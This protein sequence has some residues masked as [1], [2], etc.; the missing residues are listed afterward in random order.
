MKPVRYIVLLFCLAF[1]FCVFAQN[2]SKADFYQDGQ[3]VIITYS[4]D[5]A[6]DV[7]VQVSTDG[8][9]T[10]SAPLKHVSGHVGNNV[11]A[12]NNRIVWDV[13]SEYEKLVGNRFQFLVTA[14]GNAVNENSGNVVK[15]DNAN[16]IHNGHEYV[17]LGLPSGTL[18]ATCNVGANAPEEYGDYF[19]WGE[20]T[21]KSTYNWSTYKYCNGSYDT[22]TKYC[23]SSSYGTV[24]NKTTLEAADD[25]AR[26]NWGGAWRMPT[27]AEQEELLNECTW[28]WT[29]LNGLSGY[30]VTG[31]N[32]NS[33]FLPAAGHRRDSILGS[34]GSDG[35]YW[36][37]S[38]D[39]G[40]SVSVYVLRIYSSNFD[41]VYDYRY[42]GLSVRPV[43]SSQ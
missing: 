22:Q 4:L 40:S 37:S 38:L 19:A 11:Q 24:D 7:S 27:L 15:K 2:V 26:A 9:A 13:L 33:I 5:Q 20:T 21:P 23:T 6:A 14:K 42:F 17:D 10:F 41:W 43:C 29:T 8:G 30:R 28:S 39:S 3:K 12:G 18:W 34:A 1:P 36:S 16:N 32:G 25:A 35:Y 31:T